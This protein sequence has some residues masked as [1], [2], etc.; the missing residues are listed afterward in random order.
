MNRLSLILFQIFLV[1]IL[2]TGF[3][4]SGIVMEQMRYELKTPGKKDKG[5]LLIQDNKMLFKDTTNNVSTL[6]DF[7]RDQMI[8]LDHNG[9]TF[10]VID[11]KAFVKAIED[12]TKEIERMRQK[13]L[14]SLPPEQRE[15]VEKMMQKRELESG[16]NGTGKIVISI[17]NSGVSE[18]I[19]GYKASKYEV[20]HND[21]L[22]EEL[23]LTNDLDIQ[24]ELD[25]KKMSN[26]MTEFKKVNKRLGDD[27]VVNEE[28]FINLFANGGFP[29]KTVDRSFGET[30]YIEEVVDIKKEDIPADNFKLPS[31]YKE[32]S[33][34]ELLKGAF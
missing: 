15:M 9:Q 22:N 17:K 14:E 1:L 26:L 25:L 23:W 11:P 24:K 13:H 3:S 16:K 21:K 12:Y 32:K 10:T 28:A 7:D 19:S 4:Y 30:V 31:G 5:L 27:N 2:F 33:V 20:F 29:L 34:N 18:N 6:F 8:V